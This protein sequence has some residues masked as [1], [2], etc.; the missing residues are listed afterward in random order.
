MSK[1]KTTVIKE[2]TFEVPKG[3]LCCEKCGTT[4][5]IYDDMT[6]PYKCDECGAVMDEA[7]MEEIDLE[8]LQYEHEE[9][10]YDSQV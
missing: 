9:G 6:P 3:Q 1:K 7:N 10:K 2:K 8:E 4:N 5:F